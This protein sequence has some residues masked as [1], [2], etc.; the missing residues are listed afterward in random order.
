M[1]KDIQE[2]LFADLVLLVRE[3]RW[4]HLALEALH[5]EDKSR[6]LDLLL[7]LFAITGNESGRGQGLT[8]MG[9]FRLRLFLGMIRVGTWAELRDD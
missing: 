1:H 5:V 2:A 8:A 6:L 3:G 9:L 7:L 4:V